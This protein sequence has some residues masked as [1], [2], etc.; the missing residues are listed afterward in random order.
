MRRKLCS[1]EG[2]LQTECSWAARALLVGVNAFCLSRWTADA[3]GWTRGSCSGAGP[4]YGRS[5]KGPKRMGGGLGRSLRKG[6]VYGRYPGQPPDDLPAAF[7]GL[8][9]RSCLWSRLS[10]KPGLRMDKRLT[11]VWLRAEEGLA[12]H[13]HTVETRFPQNSPA[14]LKP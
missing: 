14:R 2:G 7:Q 9:L 8:P 6:R 12:L 3:E 1:N 13:R 5:G 11:Q 10:P 4:C